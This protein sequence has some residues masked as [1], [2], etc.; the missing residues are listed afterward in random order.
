VRLSSVAIIVSSLFGLSLPSQS[1]SLRVAPV[2][3]DLSAPAATSNI[4]LWNDASKAINVQV[5]IFR[6]TQKDGKDVF[7]PAENVVA[8]PPITQLKPGGEN[9]VRIVRT[10]KVP[11]RGEESYRLLVDELPPSGKQVATVLMVVRHSIPVF[12]AESAASSPTINWSI[13]SAPGGYEVSAENRG[14]RRF[15]L[16][17]LKIISG[18]TAVA[19]RDG[20]VG[21]VLGRS[22]ATWFVPA[23]SKGGGSLT[24]RGQNEGGSFDAK[25]KL[26]GG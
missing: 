10:S 5:R 4:R 20:L 11:V 15:K 24:I 22:T 7:L 18:S 6:W 8:S 23:S 2:V 12:F 14:D 1:A 26:L 25:A 3:I 17:D 21:Y 16:A 19:R 9:V 13:R